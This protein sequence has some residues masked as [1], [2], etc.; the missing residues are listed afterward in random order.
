MFVF[1]GVQNAGCMPDLF[2]VGFPIKIVIYYI[3]IYRSKI[4]IL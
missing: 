3:V 4:A 1:L 2:K